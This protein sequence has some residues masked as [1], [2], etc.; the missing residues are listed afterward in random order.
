VVVMKPPELPVHAE[1][2][3]S[4]LLQQVLTVPL[5]PPVTKLPPAVMMS[6]NGPPAMLISSTPPSKPL[7]NA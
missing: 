3:E 1:R 5:Y 7:S 2:P 4:G 6:V